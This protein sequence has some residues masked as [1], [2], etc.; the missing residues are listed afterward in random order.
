MPRAVPKKRLLLTGSTAIQVGSTR[1]QLKIIT[2]MSAWRIAF[3]EMGYLVDWRPTVVGESLSEYDAIVASL[4]QPNALVSAHVHGVLW[5]MMTRPDA[6]VVLDD[7]Q[8]HVLMPAFRTWS[9]SIERMFRVRGNDIDSTLR[10]KL[11]NYVGRIVDAGR[12]D[13]VSLAPVIGRYDTSLMKLPTSAHGIDPS[14]F[15]ARY[16]KGDVDFSV[17]RRRWVQASLLRKPD[18]TTS[19]GV[20]AYG[21]RDSSPGG[22]MK[23][24]AT[25]QSRLIESDLFEIYRKSWGVL[26]P[27]HFHAGSGWW[28]VRY[29]MAIDAGCVLSADPREANGLGESYTDAVNTADVEL[30]SDRELQN[31]AEAQRDELTA[32]IWPKQKVKDELSLI[33]RQALAKKA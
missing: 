1:T 27:A 23:R 33:L 8:T 13:H 10:K 2:A 7:W 14:S 4:N 9:R 16:G 12:W 31:L 11:H 21:W 18:P 24:G 15:T 20:D 17:K 5:A 22:G 29:L 3:K 19:W 28:R 30:L 26:S 6:V 32:I 25:G